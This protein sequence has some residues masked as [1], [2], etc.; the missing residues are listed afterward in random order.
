MFKGPAWKQQN[1]LPAKVSFLSF[2]GMFLEVGRG[3]MQRWI[4]ILCEQADVYG[5]TGSNGSLTM[6][7]WYQDK[8]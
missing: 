6:Q 4:I 7:R 8:N 5:A 1:S 2:T 3:S